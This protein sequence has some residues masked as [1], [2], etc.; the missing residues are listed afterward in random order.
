MLQ[1]LDQ[2]SSD[3]VD[4]PIMAFLI[5]LAIAFAAAAAVT[6]WQIVREGLA[7]KVT[8]V[9]DIYR[10]AATDDRRHRLR[11]IQGGRR[12]RQAS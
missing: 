6:W 8:T 1:L 3:A 10:D 11:S 12:D 7:T 9:D 5:L 4:R 2:L